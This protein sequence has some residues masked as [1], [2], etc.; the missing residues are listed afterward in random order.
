MEY[1]QLHID[2]RTSNGISK[3]MYADICETIETHNGEV[4]DDS[5]GPYTE[6]MSAY[7]T[8]EEMES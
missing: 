2:I 7:Y 1:Q 6:D 3:E 8:Q 5:H 4:M